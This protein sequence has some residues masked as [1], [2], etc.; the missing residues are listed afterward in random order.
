MLT[1][2]DGVFSQLMHV[3]VGR[4]QLRCE[5]GFPMMTGPFVKVLFEN[6][7]V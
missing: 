5:D 6:K 2:Q 7:V 4:T 3:W 1:P